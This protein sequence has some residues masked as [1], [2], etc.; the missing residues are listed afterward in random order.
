MDSCYL[1]ASSFRFLILPFPTEEF[2]LP[3]SWLT[4]GIDH[5]LDLIGV[6][7][8]HMC[9]T[10]PA[11]MPSLLRGLGIRS[12]D[13]AAHR[14]HCPIHHRFSRCD[15]HDVTQPH[16]RFICIHPSSFPLARLPLSARSFLRRYLSLSTPPLPVTQREIGDRPGY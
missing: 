4:R 3:Y 7:T 13:F 9:E 6:I 15:D 11:W 12:C 14:D 8:F 16:Q 1:S 5:S 2:G 10:Q